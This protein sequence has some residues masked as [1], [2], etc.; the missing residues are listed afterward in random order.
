MGSFSFL[1]FL[2]T[3]VKNTAKRSEVYTSLCHHPALYSDRFMP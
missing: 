2:P 3:D 1:S